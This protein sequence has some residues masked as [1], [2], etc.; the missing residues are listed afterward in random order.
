[1][2][3]FIQPPGTAYIMTVEAEDGGSGEESKRSASINVVTTNCM[4]VITVAMY[5]VSH[6]CCHVQC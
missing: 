4:L 1:M 2:A 3:S 5:N 6:H